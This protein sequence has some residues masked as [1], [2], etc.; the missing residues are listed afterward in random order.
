METFRVKNLDNRWMSVWIGLVAALFFVLVLV[1]MVLLS[2][3]NFAFGRQSVE[4]QAAQASSVLQSWINGGTVESLRP[5]EAPPQMD[6]TP[7]ADAPRR[8]DPRTDLPDVME[9]IRGFI[10]FGARGQTILAWGEA[11]PAPAAILQGNYDLSPQPFGD[12]VAWDGTPIVLYLKAEQGWPRL[13]MMRMF[14]AAKADA[15][16]APDTRQSG[17]LLVLSYDGSADMAVMRMRQV[18]IIM[19]GI[20][21]LALLAALLWLFR[22]VGRLQSDLEEHRALARLGTAARTL[23]HEVR[24]PLSI[25][26]MQAKLLERQLGEDRKDELQSICEEA[27]RIE[28]QVRKV[29]QILG[30]AG[31]APE[32]SSKA[33]FS[34]SPEKW[35]NSLVAAFPA[36]KGKVSIMGSMIRAEG[37]ACSLS[38]ESLRSII[39]NLVDN[40]LEAES[41]ASIK[42][43]RIEDGL[44]PHG[45]P[46]DRPLVRIEWSV[47]AAKTPVFGLAVHDQAGGVHRSIRRRIFDPFFT[48]KANGSGVGLNLARELARA[49]GGELEYRFERPAGSCFL[50]TLPMLPADGMNGEVLS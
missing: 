38:D 15:S 23:A 41:Q 5:M 44:Q 48:T 19:L 1:A 18:L 29:R 34:G 32:E 40:A 20:A 30:Q 36:W 49:A 31:Q 26:L 17:P 21:A 47:R 8:V 11:V 16:E 43:D 14:G 12:L 42:T 25:I 13:R 39:V 22:R 28:L 50:L 4:R 33:A 9:R 24:N 45:M 3:A 27:G 46:S 2:M 7:P 6:T 35:L 37:F 10:V